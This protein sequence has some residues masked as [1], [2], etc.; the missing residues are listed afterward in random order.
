MHFV[1]Q[2]DDSGRHYISRN[3]KFGNRDRQLESSWARTS[4][5][6]ENNAVAVFNDRFVRVAGHH[7]S[8]SGDIWVNIELRK[9]VNNIDE[10]PAELDQ[11]R[12]RQRVGPCAPVVVAAYH[13]DR[14]NTRELLNDH[15][16]ADITRVDD[17]ITAAQKVNRLR[18]EKVMRIRNKA[19]TNRTTQAPSNSRQVE[20]LRAF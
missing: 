2:F 20:L 6:H 18:S 13:R 5:I 7:D 14:C 19:Y 10:N 1:R 15:R 17:K 12:F 16:V 4:R 3:N 8:D 11:F 9:I